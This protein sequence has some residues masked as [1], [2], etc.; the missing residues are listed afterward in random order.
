LWLAVL[1]LAAGCTRD[2][3]FQA[4]SMWNESRL[5]PYEEAV[6]P[7]RVTTAQAPP[8]GTVPRGQPYQGEAVA[9]GRSGGKL[10]TTFPVPVTKELIARGQER[11]NINCSPC[12]GR[13]GDGAGMIVK[14]G[15]PRPPDYAIPRLRKAAVGHLYDVMTN[16][17][18]IMYPYSDRVPTGDRWA[19][20]AY[21]RV[22]QKARPVVPVDLYEAE[23]IRAR[24]RSGV[25]VPPE[26][27]AGA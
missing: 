13:L 8:V 3:Q 12:H 15:F 1:P 27:R 21:I 16:G 25:T 7:G 19:I 22:L 9:S 10:V 2:G 26:P 4:I 14:R 18:G 24:E 5:K 11:F 17:Y 23:R 6:L 20:A